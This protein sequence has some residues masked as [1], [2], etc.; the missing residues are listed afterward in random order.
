MKSGDFVQNRI[1]MI[2]EGFWVSFSSI[3]LTFQKET[4]GNLINSLTERHTISVLLSV[5]MPQWHYNV[6]HKRAQSTT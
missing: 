6:K 3:S 5:T 2:L 4:I 1:K